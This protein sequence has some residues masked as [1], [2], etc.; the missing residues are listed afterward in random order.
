[1]RTFPWKIAVYTLG[2][3]LL[4][5]V[6]VKQIQLV[7]IVLED[8]QRIILVAAPQYGLCV[9]VSS[10]NNAMAVISPYPGKA[11]AVSARAVVFNPFTEEVQRVCRPLRQKHKTRTFPSPALTSASHWPLVN[12]R[13]IKGA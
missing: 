7:K 9:I 5:L 3:L 10:P 13:M 12:S 11:D 2:L 6:V 1:M 4:L 8:G